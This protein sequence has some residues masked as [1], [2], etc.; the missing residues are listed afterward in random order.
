MIPCLVSSMSTLSFM[1]YFLRSFLGIVA[2]PFFVTLTTWTNTVTKVIPKPKV[3][4]KVA[5][6]PN[7]TKAKGMF[8]KACLRYCLVVAVRG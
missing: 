2:C 3:I 8:L 4:L 5:A 1:P 6:L 7:A